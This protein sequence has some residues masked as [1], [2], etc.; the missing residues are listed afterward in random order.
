M[1][2]PKCG[3][4]LMEGATKCTCGY[5]LTTLQK[6]I[7]SVTDKLPAGWIVL[8][9]LLMLVP[10]VGSLVVIVVSSILYYAWKKDSPNKAKTINKHGWAA[11]LVGI[12][13][14]IIIVL[15]ARRV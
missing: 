8:I 7:P 6:P 9:W 14:W 4:Q 3:A 13:F 12:G 5:D 10:Y 15:A 2:C 11:F 1:F